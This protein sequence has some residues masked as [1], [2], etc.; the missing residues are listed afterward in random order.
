MQNELKELLNIDVRSIYEDTVNHVNAE[1]Y[2]TT[3][4]TCRCCDRHQI[5]K[6][7]TISDWCE[8]PISDSHDDSCD[9]RCR[10]LARHIC[11]AIHYI[12]C[13]AHDENQHNEP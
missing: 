11:R 1:R 6:P 3:L 4:Q 9:C 8:Y 5:R 7:A 10:H 12:Q 2:L 13:I